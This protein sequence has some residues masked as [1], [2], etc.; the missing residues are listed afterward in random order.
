MQRGARA[1]R[2]RLHTFSF[3]LPLVLLLLLLVGARAGAGPA[4]PTQAKGLQAPGQEVVG[5]GGQV[6]LSLHPGISPMLLLPRTTCADFSNTSCYQCLSSSSCL[7]CSSN[8]KCLDHP[9]TAFISPSSTCAL[10][11]SYWSVCW[12]SLGVLVIIA[13]CVGGTLLLALLLCCFCL[14][15]RKCNCSNIIFIRS[16]YQGFSS[17]S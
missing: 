8:R 15:C 13:A 10:P 4:R 7:W 16:H 1:A 6:N 17:L 14:C 11:K 5:A 12:V 2:S 3:F 9:V